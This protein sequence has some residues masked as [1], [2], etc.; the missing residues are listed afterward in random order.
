[1]LLGVVA[2]AA[3][4]DFLELLEQ[5]QVDAP[6]SSMMTPLE[7]EQATTLPPS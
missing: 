4:L 3:A 2:D 5:L 6:F 1:V 7:S